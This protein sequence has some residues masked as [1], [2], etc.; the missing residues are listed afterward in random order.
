[1]EP[2]GSQTA[3]AGPSPTRL[4]LGLHP[5]D[6]RRHGGSGSFV[7]VQEFQAKGIKGFED[8]GKL[9]AVRVQLSSAWATRALKPCYS[10]RIY[11]SESQMLET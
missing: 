11:I 7:E 3:V 5:G 2:L 9:E 1:M 6:R 10:Q 4:W 8:L